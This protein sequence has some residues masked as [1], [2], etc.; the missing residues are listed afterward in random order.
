MKSASAFCFLVLI[1][2]VCAGDLA[3]QGTL[4]KESSA[5]AE[6]R[7]KDLLSRMTLEEKIDMLGGFEAFYIRPNERLGIPKVKMAD[8]PLGVRNYGKATAFPAGIAFAAAWNKDLTRTYGEMIGREARSK[9][10][11]IMLSPGVNIYRAPMCG[12]NFEYYGEDPFLASRMTVA[13]IRG[14]QS[15]GVVATVKHYAA[16]NEEYDRHTV[17]SDVDERTLRE[18]YLPAFRAAVEEA[19]VGALMT[20]YNL[21]NGVHASQHQHLINEVL[22]GDWKFDGLVMSDWTST[23]DG[24]A[25]AN[26]GL[27]LEMPSGQ[28]LNRDTLMPAIKAGNLTV[29]TIDGKIE[30]MLRIMFRFGFFDR[31]QLDE[32]LPLY[33]PESRRVALQAA[34]E[35]IVLLKNEGSLLPL[36]RGKVSSIA[37]IG[38]CAH[39]AVTGAGGSSKVEPF[40]SVSPL[41]GII[42]A[43]GD[44]L[45]VFYSAGVDYD[46]ETLFRQSQF[47]FISEKN[48]TVRGLKA[49]FFANPDLTGAPSLTRTDKQV[50]FNWGESSASPGMPTDNFSARWTGKIRADVDGDYEFYVQGDD[51]FRLS[52]RNQV[53]I[54]EWHDQ[55]ATLKS[56]KVS[57]RGGEQVD[58]RLEYYE[59][60]GDAEISLGWRRV[61]ESKDSEALRLA[62]K[63]DVAVVCVGFNPTTEGEGFDRPFELSKDQEEFLKSVASVNKK[64][65]VVLIA[66]GNVAMSGW[67]DDVGGLLH[68]WYPGQEGGTAIGEILFGDVNPS[69]KLPATFEKKWEDNPTYSSYYAREKKLAYT[70]GVFVG[71]R[72]YDKKNVDPLYP[73]GYGLSYTTFQ[74]RNLKVTPSASATDPKIKVTFEIVNTGGRGGAEVAQ[75][76][77]GEQ[78][79]AVPR[80]VRELK[81]FE[82]VWLK[83]GES[84][85]VSIDL[86][87]SA[88]AYYDVGRKEWVVKPGKFDVSVGSSSRL[89]R[90]SQ[91]VMLSK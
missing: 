11:H 25:A 16:N 17:S 28:H 50:R 85:T 14:V 56:A 37:V 81:G 20:S 48:E 6:T 8:G 18:I 64:T 88:F 62:A 43:A 47:Y 15:Q 7:V 67:I 83:P 29:A 59:H 32:S 69:G 52:L 27:D 10:V 76:Y 87:K 21:I 84:K 78:N 23:Y 77:V 5:P 70:E 31:P 82:K 12:R 51:G 63:A 66:G 57:L 42:A 24:V 9:G 55:G 73:F 71:Y 34:R 60:S 19:D 58:L 22:K 80:P 2:F 38:P 40:L 53:V 30:R 1:L 61:S 35:G 75:V 26:G 72:H 74:Y 79:P 33:N 45:K 44:R 4:Y 54:D 91:Q 86:D 46:L 41:E 90:F 89:I 68:A 65:I 36:D 39:P 49:E 3:A 13:Y